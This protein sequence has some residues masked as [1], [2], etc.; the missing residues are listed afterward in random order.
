MPRVALSA[1]DLSL[2]AQALD[3]YIEDLENSRAE[4]ARHSSGSHLDEYDEAILSAQ[5]LQDRLYDVENPDT[6]P[7]R[8]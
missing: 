8:Y 5:K 1:S 4:E 3:W 7:W 6:P 2:I